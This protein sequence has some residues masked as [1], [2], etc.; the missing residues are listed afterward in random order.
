MAENLVACGGMDCS[1]CSVLATVQ[2]VFNFLLEIAAAVAILALTVAGLIYILHFGGEILMRKAKRFLRFSLLGFSASLLA[3]LVINALYA[4]T[5]ATNK[6]NWFQLD[7]SIGDQTESGTSSSNQTGPTEIGTRGMQFARSGSV[8]GSVD[9]TKKVL[10]LEPQALDAENIYADALQLKTGQSLVF[11]AN[12][13]SLSQEDID[14]YVDVRG[15]FLPEDSGDRN[16]NNGTEEKIVIRREIDGLTIIENDEGPQFLGEVSAIDRAGNIEAIKKAVSQLQNEQTQGKKIYVYNGKNQEEKVGFDADACS[17]SGGENTIFQNECLARR[18]T[19]GHDNLACSGTENEVSGCQ[20]PAGQCL[21]GG[22]CVPIKRESADVSPGQDVD[23]DGVDDIYD[24]CSNTKEGEEINTD[25]NS[26]DA[27]CACYQMTLKKIS[28]PQ[29]RCEGQ[30]FVTYKPSGEEKCSDGKREEYTCLIKSEYNQ[31]CSQN[32]AQNSSPISKGGNQSSS[33]TGGN[34]GSSPSGGGSP[35][36][37]SPGGGGPSNSGA[38]TGSSTDT[39]SSPQNGPSSPQTLTPP[40]TLKEAFVGGNG[41]PSDPFVMSDKAMQE[42]FSYNE[43]TGKIELD[44]NWESKLGV[45]GKDFHVKVPPK[46]KIMENV[47]KKRKE[48]G[49]KELTDEE[50]E[51]LKDDKEAVQAP[52]GT[53]VQGKDGKDKSVDKK[54]KDKKEGEKDPS[55]TEDSSLNEDEEVLRTRTAGDPNYRPQNSKE[56]EAQS[57]GMVKAEDGTFTSKNKSATDYF[58]PEMA[59]KLKNASDYAKENGYGIGLTSGFRTNAEQSWLWN[60]QSGAPVARPGSSNHE[61]G[62]AAD[63]YLTNSSGDRLPMNSQNRAILRDVMERGGG[64]KNLP[65]EWWHFSTNGR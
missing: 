9:D 35:G 8:F 47:D 48:K 38:D 15:G 44:K 55:K 65:S 31:I 6:N 7:C 45:L 2:N 23:G 58:T 3:F 57:K 16:A 29:S 46:D 13:N 37:G 60:N 43:E 56:L 17:S 14:K 34:S 24:R 22:Q 62:R 40:M 26:Q 52:E 59:S 32:E 21:Q 51:K 11:I 39:G 53:K 63:V 28:C 36:G 10:E 4:V 12:K 42:A 64:L 50:K 54:E 49:K 18:A 1:V 27:G 41:S 20:C 5:G 25:K 33:P 61:F 30:F 19:C